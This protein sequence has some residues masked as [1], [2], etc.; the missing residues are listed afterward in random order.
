M[1][2][3][4]AVEFALGLCDS[5]GSRTVDVGAGVGEGVCVVADGMGGHCTGWLGARL[6]VRALVE[7]LAEA[8]G[9]ARFVGA[10]AEVPDDWGWAGA[11]QSRGAGEDAYAQCR[12]ALGETEASPRALAGLFVAIDRALREV[13][14]RSRIHGLMTGC[15]AATVEGGRVRGAH[16]G[17]GR[18]LVLRA[19]A[20]AFESL[21]VE[22]YWHALV[23]RVPLP[24]GVPAAEVPR[25]IILNGLGG[26]DALKV[27]IDAFAVELAIGDVLLLCSRRLDV[28]ED[29]VA[30]RLR[31]EL[32]AGASL[33]ALARALERR[34]AEVFTG[35][36]SYQASDV[37]FVLVRAVAG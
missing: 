32:E 13:P 36:A 10:A 2:A 15:T 5:R 9:E 23:D 37:A 18:A 16:V 22:H 34:A 26:L 7:R 28:P 20:D 27:G 11:M 17:I 33:E 3:A 12:A 6:A 24:P 31:A 19:G 25:N 21:V 35:E 14:P 29:E 8:G 4:R 30:R 1:S